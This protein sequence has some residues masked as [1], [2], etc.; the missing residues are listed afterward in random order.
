MKVESNELGVHLVSY[1]VMSTSLPNRHQ[2]NTK[3]TSMNINISIGIKLVFIVEGWTSNSLST[4]KTLNLLLSI[5]LMKR[6]VDI[7]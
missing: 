1:D 6:N 4:K 3:F 2:M 5:F 7:A